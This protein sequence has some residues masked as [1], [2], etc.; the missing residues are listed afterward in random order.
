[1][2]QLPQARSLAGDMTK[3]MKNDYLK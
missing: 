1:M 3:P 2:V